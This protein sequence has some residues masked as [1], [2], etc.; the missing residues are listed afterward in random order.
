MAFVKLITVKVVGITGAFRFSKKGKGMFFVS[1][2]SVIAGK[3]WDAFGRCDIAV[4]EGDDAGLIQIAAHAAGMF[5]IG[6]LKTALVFRVPPQIAWVGGAFDPVALE[7]VENK[8]GALVLRLPKQLFEA[9][10]FNQDGKPTPHLLRA[11]P[12]DRIVPPAAKPGERPKLSIIGTTVE[13]GKARVKLSMPQ[14]KLFSALWKAWGE[15]VRS[16]A[17]QVAMGNDDHNLV[18][19]LATLGRDVEPLGLM[20]E[21]VSGGYKLMLKA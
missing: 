14:F 13:L 6:R 3:A 20:I 10:T 21:V 8:N 11:R 1:M 9:L 2:P 16:T 17:L 7:T 15:S 5:K 12:E 18:K 4:G 19:V